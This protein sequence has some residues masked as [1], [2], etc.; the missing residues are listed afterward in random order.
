MANDAGLTTDGHWKIHLLGGLRIKRG[1][2]LILL[3]AFRS[4][5][6]LA[7]LL[8]RPPSARRV[9]LAGLLCPD[10]PEEVAKARLSDR[11][12]LLK[13]SLPDFPFEIDPTSVSVNR[14]KVWV[15]VSAFRSLINSGSSDS[16]REAVNLYAG[17]LLPEQDEEWLLLERENLHL[18]FTRLLQS[19]ASQALQS[20]RFVEAVTLAEKLHSLEPFDENNFRTLLRAHQ[21][22]GH[23]GAALAAYDQFQVLLRDEMGLDPEPATQAILK[24][25]QSQ[26]IPCSDQDEIAE[27]KSPVDIIQRCR[28]ALLQGDYCLVEDGLNRLRGI[29]HGKAA[30][31]EVDLL[32]AFLAMEQ[33]AFARAHHLVEPHAGQ[34]LPFKVLALHLAIEEKEYQQVIEAAPQL[35][36]DPRTSQQASLKAS[37]LADLALAKC[38]QG[39]P[40]EALLFANRAIQEAAQSGLAYPYCYALYAKGNIVGRQGIENDAIQILHQAESYAHDHGFRPLLAR[41]KLELGVNNRLSGKLSAAIQQFETG[42][43][44]SRDLGLQ[45]VEA[46]ILQE[47]AAVYDCLGEG[48]KS[49]HAL[50]RAQQIF[51]GLNDELGLARNMYHL[52]FAMSYHDERQLDQALVIAEKSLEILTRRGHLSWTAATLA[53]I[54]YIQWLR[55]EPQACIHAYEKAMAARE[56]LGEMDYIPEMYGYIGLSYLKMGVKEKALEN[57]RRALGDMTRSD[58]YDTN[59]E[60]YFAHATV[61]AELGREVEAN[62]FFGRAYQNLL[63]YAEEIEDP[64]ARLAFF[65]RDPTM[66]RLMEQVYARGIASP[67]QVETRLAAT[68][69]NVPV[70]VSLT[71]DAGAPDIALKNARGPV[72]LRLM[73][74]QRILNEAQAQKAK[75]SIKQIAEMLKVTPRTIQRDLAQLKTEE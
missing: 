66:R 71:L 36:L 70:K 30:D 35:L 2:T 48:Q 29:G 6:L 27:L 58:L 24:S 39:I 3:P 61:L 21:A 69:G 7:A 25:I 23:R 32:E 74:L 55:G 73:R 18:A 34:A 46:E 52:A 9:Q 45:R 62:E 5:S 28:H 12:W 57:T 59:S 17:D 44:L 4:Q 37:L 63:G 64:E 8:L 68:H 26:T 53:A 42:L 15:D 56:R 43:A 13:N 11:L 22:L 49:I 47:L 40:N 50:E 65:R 20:G 75:L 16:L 41:I 10:L 38:N 51:A 33:G 31:L 67:P 60:I 19:Q 54:G 72:K 1:E 14:Q